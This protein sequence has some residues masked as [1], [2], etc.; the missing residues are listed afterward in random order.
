MKK[1]DIYEITIKLLGIYL[2]FTSIGLLR[3]VLTVTSSIA[4]NNQYN[5]SVTGSTN[6]AFF[7]L[8][9]TNFLFV[10]VFASVLTFKTKAIVKLVCT[11][12]DFDETSTLFADRKVIYEM[13]LVIMGLLLIIWTLPD[14]AFKLKNQIQTVQ[15][16]IPTKD[17]DKHFIYASTIKIVVGLIAVVNAKS[18][19]KRIVK[20]NEDLPKE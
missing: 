16:D 1:S 19:S 3:E 10:M 17:Y 9:T 6:K 13:A 18:I 20:N 2:F 5:D 11:S 12:T 7:I 4:V 15:S 8:C 14:L